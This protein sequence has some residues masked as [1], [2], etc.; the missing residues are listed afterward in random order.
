VLALHAHLRDQ[1]LPGQVDLIPA[2]QTLLVKF[3]SH[4]NTRR[5]RTS[6]TDIKPAAIEHGRGRAIEIEVIY[7]G[8]DLESVGRLTGLGADGVIDAHTSQPWRAAF[9]G[10]APGFVFLAAESQWPDIPRRNT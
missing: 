7:D 10:F 6:I 4:R 5:A 3:D 2:M 1:P 8:E 9:G